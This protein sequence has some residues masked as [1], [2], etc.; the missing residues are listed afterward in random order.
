MLFYMSERSDIIFPS[1]QKII[2]RRKHED[3]SSLTQTIH[4]QVTQAGWLSSHLRSL[5]LLAAFQG[6]QG[7]HPRLLLWDEHA[8][9]EVA[10]LRA[11]LVLHN[12]PVFARVSGA[13]AVD[14]E[15]RGL[16]SLE[17]EVAVVV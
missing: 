9:G 13:H 2:G 6:L 12:Q 14:G 15:V 4:T 5:G 8:D 17:L 11:I 16:P 3:I 10:G 1:S 7:G